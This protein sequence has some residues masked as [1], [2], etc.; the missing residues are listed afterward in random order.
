MEVSPDQG[1]GVTL[2]PDK[3][4]DAVREDVSKVNPDIEELSLARVEHYKLQ[5]LR[6]TERH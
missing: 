3:E 2:S 6:D 1:K 5:A 4:A